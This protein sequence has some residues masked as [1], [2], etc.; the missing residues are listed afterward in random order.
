M[1]KQTQEYDIRDVAGLLRDMII[2]H[3]YA[4]R[5]KRDEVLL[6]TRKLLAKFAVELLLGPD[7]HS[8]G[9]PH[10]DTVE[11]LA[12]GLLARIDVSSARPE[13]YKDEPWREQSEGYHAKH[14]IDHINRANNALTAF[15]EPECPWLSD[16]GQPE[17]AHAALR[18]DMLLWAHKKASEK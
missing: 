14:A 18:C 9:R 11:C 12:E 17:V 4:V 13:A 7:P 5:N 16:L 6:E 15:A 8:K 10:P 3:V 2:N 1:V